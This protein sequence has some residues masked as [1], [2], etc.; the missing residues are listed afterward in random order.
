MLAI[1]ER[2]RLFAVV[3]TLVLLAGCLLV[4]QPQ[5]AGAENPSTTG[6]PAKINIRA[7]LAGAASADIA[8]VDQV[9]P[10]PSLQGK[11]IL[12]VDGDFYAKAGNDVVNDVKEKARGGTPVVFIGG[13]INGLSLSMGGIC[14]AA[15]NAETEPLVGFAAL[16]LTSG[17]DGQPVFNN[18]VAPRGS[19]N[20]RSTM[21]GVR[22][23][24]KKVDEPKTVQANGNWYLRYYS[25]IYT[26][27]AWY[28]YGRVLL[29]RYYYR[30]NNDFNPNWDFI[31]VESGNR[32][33]ERKG[34]LGSELEERLG[35]PSLRCEEVPAQQLDYQILPRQHVRAD[36][37]YVYTWRR[38]RLQLGLQCPLCAELLPTALCELRQFKQ[39]VLRLHRAQV[40]RREEFV[41]II[42]CSQ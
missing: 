2:R 8:L 25:Q 34:C 7:A 16:K 11:S 31:S 17:V 23:W 15:A 26:G 18:F 30:L 5:I 37:C 27:D 24:L 13:D 39:H 6:V 38:S 36:I 32:T 29:N 40:E 33:V 42:G 35:L 1:L 3:F 9:T 12:C 14:E 28:P 10:K 22:E 20:V 4:A 21:T 19:E 41:G